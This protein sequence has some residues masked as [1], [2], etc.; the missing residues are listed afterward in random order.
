M[1]KEENVNNILMIYAVYLGPFNGTWHI[2][3]A[4][5]EEAARKAAKLR[6]IEQGSYKDPERGALTI[7][8]DTIKLLGRFHEIEA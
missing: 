7:T 6:D 2:S 1:R 4:N 3:A 5:I 8:V